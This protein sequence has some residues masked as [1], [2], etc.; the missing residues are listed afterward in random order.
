V[1]VI[2]EIMR[3]SYCMRLYGCGVHADRGTTLTEGVMLVE[4]NE[5]TILLELVSSAS[6]SELTVTFMIP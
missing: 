5:G 6:S 3:I 4:I 1:A 2:W